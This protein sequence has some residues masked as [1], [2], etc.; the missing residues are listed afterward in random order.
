MHVIVSLYTAEVTPLR[1]L[2]LVVVHIARGELQCLEVE[3][4]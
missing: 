1:L 4:S 3:Y 2:N